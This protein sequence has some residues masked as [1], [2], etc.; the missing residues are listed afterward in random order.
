M[1]NGTRRAPFPQLGP[2]CASFAPLLPVLEDLPPEAPGTV[3]A[4]A[5][6]AACAYCRAQRGAYD[7]LDEAL[8]RHFGTD[9]SPFITTEQIMEGI[10][11]NLPD[12]A[13]VLE[14]HDS[15]DSP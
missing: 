2:E 11:D 14:S 9:A 1:L 4:R 12:G 15:H 5:H 8:L 6:V 13:P 7:R 3:E 10:R